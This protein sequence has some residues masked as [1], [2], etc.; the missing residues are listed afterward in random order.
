MTDAT[1]YEDMAAAM[2]E[3]DKALTALARWQ[4]SL[5]EAEEKIQTL[6]ESDVSDQPVK[7]DAVPHY[8]IPTVEVVE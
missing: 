3:R 1:W 4:Q 5:A 7:P 2:K 8:D 6:R